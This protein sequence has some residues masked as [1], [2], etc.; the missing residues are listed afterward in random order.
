[1]QVATVGLCGVSQNIAIA[2]GVRS[3]MLAGPAMS[4][5]R[6]ANGY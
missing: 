5:C 2:V 1:M 4:G 6:Q 3:N